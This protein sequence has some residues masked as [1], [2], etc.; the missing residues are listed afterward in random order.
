MDLS[1]TPPPSFL[2]GACAGVCA[3]STC[4]VIFE[5]EDVFDSL[6]EASEA[7]DDMLDRAFGL[8]TTSRLGCQVTLNKSHD[9]MLI[10]LPSATR[11]FYVVCVIK[12][13]IN[14]SSFPQQLL[15]QILI[16]S[17]VES[18]WPRAQAALK[19]LRLNA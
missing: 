17:Y 13:I 6:P 5:D 14:E 10:K 4:H 3:C 16:V 11:N 7:E 15:L 8:T 12:I 9:N 1:C 18:G 2:L 19:N